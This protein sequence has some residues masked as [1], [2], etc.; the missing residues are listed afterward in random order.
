MNGGPSQAADGP[1]IPSD[2]VSSCTC[3]VLPLA[4]NPAALELLV[5][6]AVRRSPELT[7]VCV[8][9]DRSGHV[10]DAFGRDATRHLGN[11]L[12]D[13][14]RGEAPAGT[15]SGVLD[16]VRLVLVLPLGPD[17][18][19]QWARHAIGDGSR[20]LSMRGRAVPM[21]V[22]AGLATGGWLDTG[23]Q[24]LDDATAALREADRRGG[25]VVAHEDA[26]RSRAD[27]HLAVEA[28]LR[29]TLDGH[30]LSLAFQPVVELPQQFVVGAEAL[31]HW[32]APSGVALGPRTAS[33]VAEQSGLTEAV[34]QWV[35]HQAAG[36]V[37]TDRWVSVKVTPAQLTPQLPGI[38]T[39]AL[40]AH[41][42]AA[43]LLRFELTAGRLPRHGAEVLSRLRDIGCRVG[44]SRFD[45][46]WSSS[47]EQLLR[48]PIDFV[49]LDPSMLVGVER[50]RR[51]RTAVS[52]LVDVAELLDLEVIAEGVDNADQA[53][54]L[55]RLGVPVQQGVHHARPRAEGH[56]VRQEHRSSTAS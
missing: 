28:E 44:L 51:T 50:D 7:V 6:D 3:Q 33:V 35:I 53:D 48:L 11:A 12:L 15:V 23:I 25:G 26:L 24:L 55:L 31:L 32:T 42:G 4:H 41:G 30:G 43:R 14:L 21:E 10:R 29:R 36:H 27:S 37:M 47:V 16:E 17:A 1:S 9:L 38:A 49:K 40:A 52:A 18:A 20:T 45:F 56:P 19:R 22:A 8:G 13:T 46:S 54:A 34:G 5:A 2:A 39:Q